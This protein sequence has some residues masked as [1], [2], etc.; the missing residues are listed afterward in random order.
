MLL[1]LNDVWDLDGFRDSSGIYVYSSLGLL[2]QILRRWLD[3]PKPLRP[4]YQE[5]VG[6][7]VVHHGGFT[8]H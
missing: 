1:R 4:S 3:P 5:V 2:S 6:A 7:L 8:V